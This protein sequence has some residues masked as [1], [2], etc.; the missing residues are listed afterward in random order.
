[1]YSA[2]LGNSRP[3]PPTPPPPSPHPMGLLP[4][5]VQKLLG[6]SPC[7]MP[8]QPVLKP[9]QGPAHVGGHHIHFLSKEK[10]RLYHHLENISRHI[11]L[12]PSCPNILENHSQFLLAFVRFLTTSDQ[13]SYEAVRIWPRYLKMSPNSV[14]VQRPG[15]PFICFPTSPLLPV[16]AVSTPTPWS[17]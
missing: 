9:H 15:S 5:S 6:L 3:H 11:G 12:D 7:N 8:G 10:Y 16:Y 2:S 17:N 13:S 1:M 4:T 14:A